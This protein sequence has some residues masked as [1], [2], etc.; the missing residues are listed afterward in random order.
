MAVTSY[1]SAPGFAYS[2]RRYFPYLE[3]TAAWFGLDITHKYY[4][5]VARAASPVCIGLGA[6]A[7][8]WLTPHMAKRGEERLDP[9]DEAL[10]KGVSD[11]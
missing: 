10:K 7:A 2:M 3:S 1:L 4:Y 5:I 11:V 6:W 9:E 8:W